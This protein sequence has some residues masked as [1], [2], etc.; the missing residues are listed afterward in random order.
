M[1]G[2]TTLIREREIQKKMNQKTNRSQRSREFSVEI[3]SPS[4]IR[5][6]THK[7]SPT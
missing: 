5:S 3:V 4:N 6:Y 7:T 2:R 1:R